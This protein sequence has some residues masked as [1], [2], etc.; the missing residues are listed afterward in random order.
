MKNT[1]FVAFKGKNNSSAILLDSLPGEHC[2]LTNSYAGLKRDIDG[3]SGEFDEVYLF[4]AAKELTDSFRIEKT[5]EKDGKKLTSKLDLDKIG[6]RLSEA[7]I[8]SRIS[9]RATHYLC[10]EAYW[11]LLEKYKGRAVLIH[12]PT[13]KHIYDIIALRQEGK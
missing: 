5:A 13:I 12:I 9:E 8:K 6:K 1:L 11:Y 7:G 4:G 3:L 10:N 2:L